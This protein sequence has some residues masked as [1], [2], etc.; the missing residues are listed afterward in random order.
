VVVP[1]ELIVSPTPVVPLDLPDMVECAI[2]GED[3]AVF[4]LTQHE[5]LIYGSQD[6]ELF[7]LTYHRTQ[8]EADEG[9]NAIENPEAFTNETN[10]QDIFVRLGFIE[11]D[12]CFSTGMF[13]LI[14]EPEL[15]IND[16]EPYALCAP[17]GEPNSE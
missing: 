13:T 4:D 14:V 15:P 3:F 11:G 6:P 8:E 7:D 17:I 2:D 1:L 10:P 5:E 9:I 12:G 16:P